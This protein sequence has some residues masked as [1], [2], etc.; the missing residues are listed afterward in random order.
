MTKP[1]PKCGLKPLDEIELTK[2]LRMEERKIMAYEGDIWAGYTAQKI[3]N[4]FGIKR[5]R[6]K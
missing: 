3:C 4:L 1:C 2:L 6:E 5:R